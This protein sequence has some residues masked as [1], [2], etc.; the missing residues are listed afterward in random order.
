M[1]T[2][3]RRIGTALVALSL[4]AGV[5]PAASARL[6]G[7]A[8]RSPATAPASV[9]DRP[10]RTMVPVDSS[11]TVVG[12]PVKPGA[13]PPVVRV[14]GTSSGFDWGDA[15]IGAA[16]ALGLSLGALG[17]GLVLVRRRDRRASGGHRRRSGR[18]VPHPAS[19]QTGPTT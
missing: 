17:G 5:A 3:H 13:A 8:F 18:A 1:S 12:V 16:A 19:R 15:G 11:E 4:T 14:Q 9:Y 7:P 2:I 6:I 10:D